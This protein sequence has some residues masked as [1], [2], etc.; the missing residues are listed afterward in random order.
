MRIEHE[1][2]TVQVGDRE[3]DIDKAIAPLI[4]ELW[5]AD[6]DTVMSCQE[7]EP[8]IIWI[9]F[10]E[11]YDAERFLNIVGHVEEGIDTLYN[12]ISMTWFDDNSEMSA[13]YWDYSISVDDCAQDND[14]ETVEWDE[15]A[16]RFHLSPSI[17]FP[18][19]DYDVVLRRMRRHNA[20]V[21]Q[22]QSRYPNFLDFGRYSCA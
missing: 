4:E 22:E 19:S 2:V 21:N 15:D 9:E 7:N 18:Q 11:T 12:R 16:P 1:Q 13:P 14:G 5:K 17:R 20:K 10:A 3:A 6:I 8:G